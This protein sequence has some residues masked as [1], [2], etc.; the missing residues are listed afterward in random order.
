MENDNQPAPGEPCG[1][2]LPGGGARAAYQ[3]GVV[4]A[5]AEVL[6]PGAPNPFP[7]ITGTSA[8]AINAAM[9]A[10]HAVE[11][12]R[13]AERLAEIW[14]NLAVER[15]FRADLWTM[16]STAARWLLTLIHGGNGRHVPR[17]LLDNS[18]LRKLLADNIPFADVDRAI[19]AGALRA[20]AIVASGYS[21][22][23]SVA[24]F[25]GSRDIDPWSRERR[26]GRRS[27]I[28]LDHIM[29]S[30][31]LPIIFPS[32]RI[33]RE[34]FGDGSMRQAAPLSAA[35]HLGASKILI[36]AVRNEQANVMP[37]TAVYPSF[38]EIAGY[39]LDTLFMDTL[40]TDLER[41]KRINQTYEHVPEAAREPGTPDLRIIDTLVIAPSVDIG[42]IADRHRR[43]FPHAVNVMLKRVGAH[44]SDGN[45]LISYLLFS[46]AFCRELI[47]L[48]Y[49]DG[50]ANRVRIREFLGV[51]DDA[52]V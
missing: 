26:D 18:P 14:E 43:E 19:D 11:F 16:V 6:P 33:E 41:L 29:A 21:S 50:L 28:T 48:G 2:V 5:V 15:V 20:L 7:I 10:S 1:L 13:G 36:V 34:F 8:G 12:Q 39:V 3:A 27:A 40:Y 42:E 45:Q 22:A 47:E 4:K 25:N 17:A 9:L 31:A 30:I 32:V 52:D 24:F 49:R 46:G 37:Q 44:R 38:G 35:I 23:R 51:T